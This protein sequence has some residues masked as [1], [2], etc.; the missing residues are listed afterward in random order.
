M[1]VNF[2]EDAASF[3]EAVQEPPPEVGKAA[4]TTVNLMRGLVDP[5]TGEWQSVA[6]VV[7]MTGEDE[8]ALD[9]LSSKDDLS[10]ADYTSALLRRSV[11]AIG[12]T[13]VS[14]DPSVLDNLM[15]G[16]RDLL[17]LGVIRA[18]YGN[19]RDFK[20]I[21]PSC[22]ESNEVKVNL[23]TDFEME[24]PKGDA[25]ST[26]EITL[27]NG[28]VVSIK[29]LTGKDAKAVASSGDTLAVQNT[30]IV[31]QSVIWDD[32]RSIQV[33]RSWAKSL[34][35]ADRKTIVRAV[36]D[37]QPGPSLVEV[38]APCAYCSEDITMVLDWVSL[39]LG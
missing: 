23:D 36:L 35:L 31:T 8:E 27:K 21:C 28:S 10:Y 22:K 24:S 14:S 34:S 25:R 33:R 4:P 3:N 7:E 15:I 26:R 32:D 12:S 13:R 16:D 17:F 9:L 5:E 37:D 18:T 30:E 1:S 38:N 6:T 11:M 39:L 29:Y 19:I 2:V 20:L